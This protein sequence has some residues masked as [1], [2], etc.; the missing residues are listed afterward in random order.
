[1]LAIAD[2]YD[3]EVNYLAACYYARAG[4]SDKAFK[5]MAASLEKGYANY[6]NWAVNTEADVNVE[7]IRKDPR[8]SALLK[9]N[10]AI[11]G[12]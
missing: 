5:C 8:F 11:F 6:Y 4:N 7:P 12:R 1:M 9:A 10:G 3:G 2:D